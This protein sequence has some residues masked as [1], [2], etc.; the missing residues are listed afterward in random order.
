MGVVIQDTRYT[1]DGFP[2]PSYFGYTSIAGV[3]FDNVEVG[4][5]DY[6]AREMLKAGDLLVKLNDK[7]IPYGSNTDVVAATIRSIKQRPIKLGIKRVQLP[8]AKLETDGL[9]AVGTLNAEQIINDAKYRWAFS[10]LKDYIIGN[11][12]NSGKLQVVLRILSQSQKANERVV[13]FSQSL[14]ALDSISAALN[15]H[16]SLLRSSKRCDG[17]VEDTN[18]NTHIPKS[19]IGHEVHFCVLTGK[20]HTRSGVKT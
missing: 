2:S 9:E 17:S 19:A 7:P 11:V 3:S 8:E 4:S 20:R 16:N 15:A 5:H 12:E 13:L 1:K 10:L 18:E 6:R 14:R